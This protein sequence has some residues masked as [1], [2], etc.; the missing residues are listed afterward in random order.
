M[1]SN[2]KRPLEM[3]V[4]DDGEGWREREVVADDGEGPSQR[5]RE[6][7]IIASPGPND[8]CLH[9]KAIG[10]SSKEEAFQPHG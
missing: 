8:L 9:L 10:I 5:E 6:I 3:V 2:G 4:A 1:A 7:Y